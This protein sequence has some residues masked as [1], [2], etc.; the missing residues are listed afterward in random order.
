MREIGVLYGLECGDLTDAIVR[1]DIVYCHTASLGQSEV[2]VLLDPLEG[3]ILSAEVE[4]CGP[5]VTDEASVCIHLILM[6]VL[7]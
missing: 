5:V 7:R 2:G 1:R 6:L 3:A 4:S